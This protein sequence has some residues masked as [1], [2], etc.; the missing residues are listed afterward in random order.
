[1]SVSSRRQLPPYELPFVASNGKINLEWYTYLK[2]LDAEIG[3]DRTSVLVR[4]LPG[5]AA[6]PAPTAIAG[7]TG[8]LPLVIDGVTYNVVIE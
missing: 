8:T 6:T 5:P 2:F 1:M 4:T 3:G 7:A